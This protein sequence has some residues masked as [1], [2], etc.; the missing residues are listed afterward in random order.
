MGDDGNII[1]DVETEVFKAC[2]NDLRS[3]S[4]EGEVCSHSLETLCEV[5]ISVAG[6]LMK[7]SF[8]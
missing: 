4:L 8:G 7:F 3:M 1:A 2:P 5:I 6:E